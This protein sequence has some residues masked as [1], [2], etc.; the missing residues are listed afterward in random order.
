MIF[1][2]RWGL[3]LRFVF[4]LGNRILEIEK[5]SYPLRHPVVSATID[6][7]RQVSRV[8]PTL[9]LSVLAFSS[10]VFERHEDITEALR[11]SGEL[12]FRVARIRRLCLSYQGYVSLPDATIS[13]F[14]FQSRRLAC[15]FSC[16][17][18]FRI[19]FLATLLFASKLIVLVSR[20]F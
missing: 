9:P 12:L 3:I 17:L 6:T 19:P 15:R 16:A 4:S 8:P 2:P 14:L 7:A 1:L 18:S 20:R 11:R 10:V 13:H 5:H